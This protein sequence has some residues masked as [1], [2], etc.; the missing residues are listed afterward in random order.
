MFNLNNYKKFFS[1][2]FFFLIMIG[3][4]NVRES[5]SYPM[6]NKKHMI[7]VRG[8]VYADKAELK[9]AW[10]EKANNV[11]PSGFDVD[12]LETKEVTHSGYKK[13]LLEGEI[14]CN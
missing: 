5:E 7:S 4:Q 13:P 2:I 3:C 14:I 1:L 6:G 8:N 12:K 11:C 9:D 10:Y